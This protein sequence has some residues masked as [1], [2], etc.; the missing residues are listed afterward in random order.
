MQKLEYTALGIM[1]GTSLDGLDMAVC[2]FKNQ[3]KRWQ[4]K[5]LHHRTFPYSGKRKAFLSRL[6]ELSAEELV[7]ADTA[8]ARYIAEKANQFIKEC[9]CSIDVIGSHG[10]TLFHQPEKGFTFQLGAG[11]VIAALTG[12]DTVS[13]FRL[14]DVALGG[15]GAPLVPV[16]DELLFSDYQA[17]L[18]IGG[19]ANLSFRRNGLRIAFD[20]CPANMILNL[21]AG[22]KGK[23]YDKNGAWASEGVV[24]SALLQKLNNLSYYKKP[25]PKSLSREWFEKEFYPILSKYKIGVNDKLATCT[26][27]IAVQIARQIKRINKKNSRVLVTGGGAKNK[28]LTERLRYHTHAEI[29]IPDKSLIDMKEA[30]V[31]AF[32][33]VLRISNNINCLKS[34]TGASAD[35]IC[36][37]W[38]KGRG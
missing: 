19:I 3:G 4:Y 12:I 5:L 34:V 33:A 11:A 37:S 17:C 6:P 21:L 9:R 24:H 16:G 2:S 20:V 27:H 23:S 30:I 18:N 26:E 15:Q 1:S 14:A 31:F 29:V 35:T 22:F 7:Q 28:F 8:Y 38:D 32:L 10:H 25:Y 36:G 13:N